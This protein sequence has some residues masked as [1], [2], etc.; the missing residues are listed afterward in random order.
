[1]STLALPAVHAGVD[2]LLTRTL[3]FDERDPDAPRRPPLSDRDLDILHVL[4]ELRYLTTTM[5]AA[6]A[7]GSYNSRLRNR[8]HTLF[9]AG[10][11]RRFRPPIVPRGGGAQWIYELDTKG[12]RALADRRPDRCPPWSRSELHAF[13]YA[14]H[15]LELNALLCELAARAA[16]HHQ[17]SGPLVHAAPFDFHGARSGTIDPDREDRPLDADPANELGEGEIVRPGLSHRGPLEP[18]ATLIGRH[19]RTGAPVAVLIEYDRTRRATK[20]ISKLAR[21]DHFLADGWRRTR[22]ARQPDEPAVLFVTSTEQH[23]RNVLREADRQLTAATGSAHDVTRMRFPGRE[24]LAITSR[25]RLLAGDD[26][27]LQV[28]PRPSA[29][30]SDRGAA[31]TVTE[32][33]LSLAAVFG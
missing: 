22:Y 31:V 15:D 29:A 8:L 13:S 16:A 24:E 21:Y 30:S 2:A 27:I 3:H 23:V 14:E 10:L 7:W 17:R 12:H 20:L 4:A 9:H 26:R 19:H 6:L 28:T 32:A 11:I 25:P 1:M 33:R 5:I 18:D